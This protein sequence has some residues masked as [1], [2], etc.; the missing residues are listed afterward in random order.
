[1]NA[2]LLNWT[3][4]LSVNN[5]REDEGCFDRRRFFGDF[6]NVVVYHARVVAADEVQN[7]RDAIEIIPDFAGGFTRLEG[8]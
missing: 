4:T 5:G 6:K 8:R 2:A 3:L 1:M 7:G